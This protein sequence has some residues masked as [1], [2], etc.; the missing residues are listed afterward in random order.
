MPYNWQTTDWPHFT[1]SLSRVNDVLYE[2]AKLA[3]RVAGNLQTISSHAQQ[4]AVI[5][6]MVQEAI[7]TSKIEGEN[8]NTDDI[9]SSL[10]NHLNL[11][12][13]NIRVNDPRAEGIANLMLALRESFQ[14]D[15]SEDMLFKWHR[16]IFLG[17]KFS[18]LLVGQWRQSTDPMQII[19]GPIGREKVFFEAPP[20][21]RI[22]KEMKEFITWFNDPHTRK[23]PGPVR[24]GIA[25]LYFESIH[26]FEDGNGRIGRALSEKAL[27][28]DLGYPCIFSLS[29]AINLQRKDYYSHLTRASSYT[30]DITEWLTYFINIVYEAQ[31]EAEK[32]LCYIVSKANFWKKYEHQLNDRQT[33]ILQRMFKEGAEGFEGGINARKYMIITGCSKA[34]ATR[35]LAE[36]LDMNCITKRP[37]RGRSTSYDINL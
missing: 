3:G 30:L 37:S 6:L 13:P 35:D 29:K 8:L 4:E 32:D 31:K 24:A 34:T 5:D 12:Y 22:P 25:H 9:R 21:H 27:S 26:P 33:R 15:L 11:N 2:Y 19:S 18:N 10:R 20:S 7:A 28:Q 23:L 1:F 17:N 16:L 14:D 36:M